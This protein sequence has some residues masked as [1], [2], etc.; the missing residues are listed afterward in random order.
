[1]KTNREFRKFGDDSH[2][3]EY[4]KGKFPL[5]KKKSKRSIY[6]EIEDDADIGYSNFQR[7]ESVE[8]YFD[9]YE[10]Y[11]DDEFG[12]EFDFAD[13]DYDYDYDED[14]Y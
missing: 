7:K 1:M 5:K 14:E 9:D 10:D 12:E 11:E 8:D 2:G 6:E 4:G 3:G 13:D